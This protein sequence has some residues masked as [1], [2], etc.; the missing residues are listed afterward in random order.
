MLIVQCTLRMPKLL[1]PITAPKHAVAPA[2]RGENV[3]D[4]NMS[5]P[6][7]PIQSL[8]GGRSP[9]Y[10][11]ASAGDAVLQSENSRLYPNLLGL[12]DDTRDLHRDVAEDTPQGRLQ[13]AHGSK[14]PPLF[15]P[16]SPDIDE[17]QTFSQVPMKSSPRTQV[18]LKVPKSATSVNPLNE[19]AQRVNLLPSSTAYDGNSSYLSDDSPGNVE[20]V[21]AEGI[22]SLENSEISGESNQS[23]NGFRI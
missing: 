10:A 12:N 22:T 14:P 7:A 13:A 16:L 18:Q 17:D 5:S 9:P 19:G 23:F 2:S 8:D 15:A 21:S 6:G 11:H 3:V 1:M 20:R 4:S